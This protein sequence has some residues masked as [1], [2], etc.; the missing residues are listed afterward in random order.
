MNYS[1]Y[2]NSVGATFQIP[3]TN[4][5][6]AA[7]FSVAA[8]NTELPRSIDWVENRI[9]RDLDFLNSYVVD[10]SGTLTANSRLF[11]LPTDVGTYIVVTQLSLKVGGVRQPPMLPMTEEALTSMYP[12]DTAI[13][14][15]SYPVYWAPNNGTTVY[16]GPAPD[17]N[18]SVEVRGTQRVAQLSSTNT[19]NAL[20]IIM[21]DLYIAAGNIYFAMFQRDFL[22]AQGAEPQGIMAFEQAYKALLQ[23]AFVEELRRKFQSQGWQARLP[24][25]VAQPPQS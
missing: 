13:G 9:Q 2:V 12:S 22:Q 14:T 20:S 18:Y 15:P 25:P 19:T 1:D 24:N 5:A 6:L 3:V 10:A 11:T 4:P 7:P 16:V 17:I 21:P 8:Y 23:P